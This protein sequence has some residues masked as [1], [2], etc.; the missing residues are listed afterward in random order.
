MLLLAACLRSTGTGTAAM[1]IVDARSGEIM[2]PGKIVSYGDGEKICL[3]DVDEGLLSARALVETTYRDFGS[4]NRRLVI[5]RQWVPLAV[6][7][8][9]PAFLFQRVAFIPS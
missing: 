2:T 6:R 7:F 4:A 3:I 5:A 1:K 8:T 9:H